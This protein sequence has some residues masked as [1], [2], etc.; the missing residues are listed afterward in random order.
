MAKASPSPAAAERTPRPSTIPRSS[1]ASAHRTP[2]GAASKPPLPR[3][4]AATTGKGV[5]KRLAY[6]DL[7]FPDADLAPLLDL[8]D[9]AD[10]STTVVSAAPEDASDSSAL[11]EV[12]DSTVMAINVEEKDPLP[13][14]ITL[15][16]AELHA[17]HAL[18][19]R[20]RRLVTALV[21]AAAAAEL[22]SSTAT[23]ARL[24][25]AAFW[26]KL[27]VAV[28]AA[29]VAAVAAVDVAL[30]VALLSSRRAGDQ[31]PPT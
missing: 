9:P 5:A 18:S 16:L 21:E 3:A 28:L 19:P 4:D 8:P 29:M 13:E 30:A 10:S 14:Q 26:G 6:D 15:A 22:C 7:A 23:A 17:D 27:R 11:T 12:A 2:I 24:R 20:S 25:R 1:S 31:L